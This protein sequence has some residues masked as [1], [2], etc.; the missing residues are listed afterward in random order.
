VQQLVLH[1]K[2]KRAR[3]KQANNQAKEAHPKNC[4]QNIPTATAKS[5]NP[6]CKNSFRECKNLIACGRREKL[7]LG[8]AKAIV[9]V[10]SC[11]E[12]WWWC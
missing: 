11:K 6:E 8:S 4:A 10:G 2:Q 3:N 12:L 7:P 5:A 1:L 9:D